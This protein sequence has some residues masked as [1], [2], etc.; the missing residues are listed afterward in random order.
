MASDTLGPCSG[1]VEAARAAPRRPRRG[2]TIDPN[3]RVMLGA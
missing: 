3:R 2:A 1:L